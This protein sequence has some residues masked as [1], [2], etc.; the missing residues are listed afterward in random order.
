MKVGNSEQAQVL[1]DNEDVLKRMNKGLD[2]KIAV[3][4]QEIQKIDT[5]YDK[6]I[7]AAKT[8]GEQDYMNNLDRNQ[9]RIIGETNQFEEKIKGYQDRLQAAHDNVASEETN[10]KTGHQARVEN[11]KKDMENNFQ[12]QY[13]NTQENSREIQANNKNAIKDITTKSKAEKAR[14]QSNASFEV[15]AL[16]TEL[17]NKSLNVKKDYRDQLDQQLKVHQADMA[18]QRDELK[19]SALVETNNSKRLSDE[20]TK[21]NQN[22]LLYQD[23]HQQEMLKQRNA[24]FKVRYENMVKQHDN[25]LKE[26]AAHLDIDVK[27]MIEKTA[28][29][30]KI[31]DSRGVDPFYHVDTLSPKLTEDLKT[32]TVMIP[33][34]EYEKEN[35]H[36]STQGRLVKITLSRKFTDSLADTDGTLNR[37]T[38]SE[39]FSKELPTKDLLNPKEITQSYE[40]GVLTYK[41]KKA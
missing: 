38:R 10:L 16:S 9:H 4:E 21:V 23:K 13:F 41:I 35:L 8:I 36:L 37:S 32:V 25:T 40:A 1:K 31:H 24:D 7:E 27:K 34:A 14:V 18:L 33:I 29:T 12:D 15:N 39:L 11:M 6:K 3:K 22:Q 20:K 26:L 19:K 28:D 2:R 30:K 17:N 5:L